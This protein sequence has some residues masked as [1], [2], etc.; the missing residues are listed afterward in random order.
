MSTNFLYEYTS[1]DK[2]CLLGLIPNNKDFCKLIS[3]LNQKH[4]WFD[5]IN[6]L[7]NNWIENMRIVEPYNV[8]TTNNVF[9]SNDSINDWSLQTSLNLLGLYEAQYTLS[10]KL[11]LNTT[12]ISNEKIQIFKQGGIGTN[13]IL[14]VYFKFN[15]DI[16]PD[17]SLDKLVIDVYL[18][19]S[20]GSYELKTVELFNLSYF[21]NTDVQLTIVISSS[22]NFIKVYADS[23]LI[24]NNSINTNDFANHPLNTPVNENDYK[25]LIIGG[26]KHLK[27][28]NVFVWKRILT[29]NE[30]KFLK[31]IL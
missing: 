28:K 2:H 17:G 20:N 1:K 18:E 11:N 15:K 16:A 6:N 30:I 13:G 29:D 23:Q 8:K 9:E 24:A 10:T 31:K 14:D 3:P 25:K 19:S 12:N 7:S 22:Q 4:I 21:I 26:S 27:L 5:P